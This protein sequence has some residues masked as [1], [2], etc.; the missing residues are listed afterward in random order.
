M[1]ACKQ[2]IEY[3]RRFTIFA[4][5]IYGCSRAGLYDSLPGASTSV[6]YQQRDTDDAYLRRIILRLSTRF[7]ALSR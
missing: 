3:T 7:P 1:N 6:V 2:A 5:G 4:I